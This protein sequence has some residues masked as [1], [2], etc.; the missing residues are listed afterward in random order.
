MNAADKSSRP[1]KVIRPKKEVIGFFILMKCYM[2]LSTAVC[3]PKQGEKI[4]STSVFLDFRKNSS[5]SS[6]DI[7][8]EIPKKSVNTEYTSEQPIVDRMQ[9]DYW[10]NTV[11]ILGLAH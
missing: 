10:A 1:V 7:K 2:E 6:F 8:E 4:A 11:G 5:I 9:D 3:D